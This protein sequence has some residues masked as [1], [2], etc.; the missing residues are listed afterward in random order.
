M[1]CSWALTSL[2]LE[3]VQG[4]INMDLFSCFHIQTFTKFRPAPF[5]ED[6][7]FFLLYGLGLF[8]FVNQVPICVRDYFWVFSPISL[9]IMY[10]SLPIPCSFCHYWSVI[11][12]DVRGDD[13]SNVLL[14]FRIIL[15][16]LSF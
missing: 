5:V 16:T 10:V 2:G 11:Y 12:L 13:S 1:K 15:T 3:F 14:L 9:T 8:V 7:F 4:R 6:A